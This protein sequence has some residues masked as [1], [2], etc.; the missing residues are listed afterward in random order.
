MADRTILS[1]A[2]A[3][4]SAGLVPHTSRKNRG[5]LERAENRSFKLTSATGK[6]FDPLKIQ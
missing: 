2:L 4:V 6:V 5:R 1:S 3:T